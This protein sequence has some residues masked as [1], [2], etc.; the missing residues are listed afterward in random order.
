MPLWQTKV[1]LCDDVDKL[2]PLVSR[3]E[4][5]RKH[6]L[7]VVVEHGVPLF[8]LTKAVLLLGVRIQHRHPVGREHV[9]GN[10]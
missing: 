5:F 1:A 8:E 6:G 10:L 2:A 3:P 9:V 7:D 4:Q